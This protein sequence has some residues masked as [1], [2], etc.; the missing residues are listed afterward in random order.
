MRIKHEKVGEVPDSSSLWMVENVIAH[1][2]GRIGWQH[3]IRLRSLNTS[4]YLARGT[5]TASVREAM[6]QEGD[7]ADLSMTIQPTREANNTCFKMQPS[8]KAC[9]LSV[10]P[11]NQLAECII[12]VEYASPF[13]QIISVIMLSPFLSS[14]QRP[15]KGQG[16]RA[17]QLR[18]WRVSVFCGG[19]P[20]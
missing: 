10:S 3:H 18:R 17:C 13:C 16:R 11:P 12:S 1:V 15:Y 4:Q 19:E 14:F 20:K 2:G 7:N 6:E 8:Q 5:P 9:M